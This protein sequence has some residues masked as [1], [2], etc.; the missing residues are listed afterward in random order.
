MASY[1]A[2]LGARYSWSTETDNG[3]PQCGHQWEGGATRWAR[4]SAIGI[5]RT[6]PQA[7]QVN[8]KTVM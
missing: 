1:A 2:L 4:M 6:G 3:A 8:T 5:T 7:L